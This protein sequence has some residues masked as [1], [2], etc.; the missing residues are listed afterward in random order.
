MIIVFL[1]L[2]PLDPKHHHPKNQHRKSFLP[3]NNQF[4]SASSSDLNRLANLTMGIWKRNLPKT[5]SPITQILHRKTKILKPMPTDSINLKVGNQHT[6]SPSTPR[7]W[8]SPKWQMSRDRLLRRLSGSWRL[9]KAGRART[10]YPK[11]MTPNKPMR[12]SLM[13]NRLLWNTIKSMWTVIKS[14]THN[15]H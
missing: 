13:A 6:T 2:L 14:R 9:R 3:N 5:K 7:P 15:S 12:M 1:K 10:V 8:T 4:N 11:T